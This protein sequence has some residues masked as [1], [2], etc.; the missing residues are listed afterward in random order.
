MVVSN[1]F[2]NPESLGKSC[3]L[4]CAYFSNGSVQPPARD[5]SFLDIS[6][7]HILDLSL[8]M[9]SRMILGPFFWGGWGW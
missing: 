9:D 7:K 3:N 6:L 8:T 2:F 4:T 1:I 5:S